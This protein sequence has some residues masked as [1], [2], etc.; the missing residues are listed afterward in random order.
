VSEVVK[1]NFVLR[2]G[3]VAGS[4]FAVDEVLKLVVRAAIPVCE[5]ATATC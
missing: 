2:A 4:C 5:K 1:A 3:I